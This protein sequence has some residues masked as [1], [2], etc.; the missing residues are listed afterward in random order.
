MSQLGRKQ[1]LIDEFWGS[2]FEKLLQMDTADS[3]VQ[4]FPLN[5]QAISPKEALKIATWASEF[6][7]E[8]IPS[9]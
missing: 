6:G 4:E 1:P 9:N 2:A 7:Q 8:R 3:E 5:N